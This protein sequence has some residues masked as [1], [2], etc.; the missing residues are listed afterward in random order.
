MGYSCCH[1]RITAGGIF[2]FPLFAPSL[3]ARLQLSQSQLSMIVLAGMMGQYPFATLWGLVIDHFGPWTCSLSASA[4]FSLGF[5]LFSFTVRTAS[6]GGFLNSQ[7]YLLI[8]SFFLAGSG[9]V[10]SYFSCLFSASKS[11]PD[12]TGL[13]A[14]IVTALFGL[15]P[16]FLS[17]IGNLFFAN[18]IDGF[19]APGYLIF[20]AVF[21]GSV[22]LLG[23]IGLR[24]VPRHDHYAIDTISP[25]TAPAI[26]QGG[27]EDSP[28]LQA[29][30]PAIQ[31]ETVLSLLKDV[32]FWLLGLI[33]LIVMGMSE[34][35][36][37]NIG[38]IVASFVHAQPEV[39]R[40][41]TTA[42]SQI[43]MIS[44]ANTLSRLMTGPVADFT[45]PIPIRHHPGELVFHPKRA[46]TRVVFVMTPCF[47][48]LLSFA[49]MAWGITSS[50]DLWILSLGTGAAY[51][52]IWTV[53]PSLTEAIWGSRHVAR[54]FGT[55]SYAPFLGTPIFTLLYAAVSDHVRRSQSGQGPIC[56][57]K[58]CW[59][60]T[61]MVCTAILCGRV[62]CLV[63]CGEDGGGAC[64]WDAWRDRA[65]RL[66]ALRVAPL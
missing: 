3:A 65:N 63:F 1:F 51:G 29:D 48:L 14:G 20:L 58:G 17:F 11:F 60:P 5:G 35:V 18:Q 40:P 12:N 39:D 55:I 6:E 27:S 30:R 2:C 49:W 4:F 31:R 62:R 22:N 28:L 34:M 33:M 44:L 43:R 21:S 52:M 37:S 45:S 15:S 56:R 54:N 59:T 41:P 32:D 57:G 16:L 7:Y 36:I 66:V 24:S 8:F 38:T 10:A 13:A 64:E 25:D 53:V 46:V 61:F 23:A 19:D 42:G 9:T 26:P 47:L 50:N